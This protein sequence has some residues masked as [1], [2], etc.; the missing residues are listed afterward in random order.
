MR[1]RQI[2]ASTKQVLVLSSV[3]DSKFESTVP[4]SL[5]ET[6]LVSTLEMYELLH[7]NGLGSSPYRGNQ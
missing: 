2:N 1:A 3:T 4:F 6:V 7:C 5:P